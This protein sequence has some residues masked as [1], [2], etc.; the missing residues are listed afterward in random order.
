MGFDPEI[1]NKKESDSLT[2]N[3]AL[4]LRE[5]K[6]IN[7]INDLELPLMLRGVSPCYCRI[8]RSDASG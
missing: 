5:L 7:K 6:N 4:Q 8:K 3:A 1:R 2:A